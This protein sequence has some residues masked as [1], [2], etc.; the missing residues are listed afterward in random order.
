MTKVLGH[1][2]DFES[3]EVTYLP[4]D[5]GLGLKGQVFGLKNGPCLVFESQEVNSL[6][7]RMVLALSLKV[8]RSSIWP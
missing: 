7:L 4:F 3:H 6:A 1:C 2:H 5:T 8:T